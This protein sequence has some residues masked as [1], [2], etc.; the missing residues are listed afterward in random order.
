MMLFLAPLFIAGFFCWERHSG[1]SSMEII[2]TGMR[3]ENE[4][5]QHR[6]AL[7]VYKNQR[8]G[9][10]CETISVWRIRFFEQGRLSNA[11][12]IFCMGGRRLRIPYE[13]KGMGH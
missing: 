11:E 1:A 12:K 5:Y 8:L 9:R 2:P 7:P 4:I 6:K 13:I 3:C 10:C